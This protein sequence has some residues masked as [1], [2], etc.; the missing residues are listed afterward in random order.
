VREHAAA[1][2]SLI[3]TLHK[4]R[5]AALVVPSVELPKEGLKVLADDAVEH[6]MLRRATHVGSRNRLARSRGVKVHDH[7]T[8]S[9]L[10]PL[11]APA[12]SASL[13]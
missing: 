11:F 8:P 7:R 3:L 6:P 1:N 12:F 13:R 10:V 5:G 2:E 9:R 4:Q